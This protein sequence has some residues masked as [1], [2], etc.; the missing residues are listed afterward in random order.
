MRE[1]SHLAGT[2]RRAPP[3]T[4]AASPSKEEIGMVEVNQR[5]GSLVEADD[6]GRNDA[7]IE[8]ALV[9]FRGEQRRAGRA[10]RILRT[11]TT[12]KAKVRANLCY[13]YFV[14]SGFVVDD[15][16]LSSRQTKSQHKVKKSL[17]LLIA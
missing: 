6:S 10:N 3:D 8:A 4:E 5:G 1:L 12:D 14:F 9:A 11:S 17:T 7:V 15:V 2:S 13:I 16:P